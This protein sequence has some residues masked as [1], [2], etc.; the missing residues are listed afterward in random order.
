V[1]VIH[2]ANV[3]FGPIV[4]GTHYYLDSPPVAA[5]LEPQSKSALLHDFYRYTHMRIAFRSKLA[6]SH[7]YR[8]DIDGLR[9]IAVLAVVIFHAK[10]DLLPGGF[11]GVDIFFVISGYLITSIVLNDLQRSRFSI[12][13]F[14][15]RRVRRIFPALFAVLLFC[16]LAAAAMF[17]PSDLVSFG[18]A[19][20]AATGFASNIYFM[21]S[22]GQGGYFADSS[23]SQ[24]LLHTWTLS[25]EEQFYLF[26]PLILL[27]L[28]R[29]P[30]QR[31]VLVVLLLAVAS[32]ASSIWLTHYHPVQ[33]FYNLPSRAWELLAGALLALKCLPA[34]EKRAVRE[35]L[36]ACGL[37]LIVC[38][39]TLL[40]KD[41]T[42]P[43]INAI[44][45]CLG[46]SFMLYAGEQGTAASKS[47]L[48]FAPLVF[49][50][51]ISY[52]LY[53]WHWPLLVFARCFNAGDLSNVQTAGAVVASFLAAFFSYE[54]IERPFR[55]ADSR[56]SRRKI[57]AFGLV[58]SAATLLL[59]LAIYSSHGAPQRFNGT[60]RQIVMENAQRK[61]DFREVCSNWNTD[62]H[63]IEDIN[64]CTLG[65]NRPRKILFW[66]D[67][68]VQQLYPAIE[69]LFANG[70][71][72]VDGALVA[73]ENGCPP[74]EHMNYASKG[75]HCDSFAKLAMARAEMNDIDTVFIGFN[76]WWTYH[77]N[78][79]CPSLDGICVAHIS[80]D[81]SNNLFLQD[82]SSQ[83]AELEAHG[84]RVIV[85]LPFP[86]YDKSIPDL[87][88]RNAIFGRYGLGAIATDQ[89]L[90][91]F[92]NQ[93]AAT[94]KQ[95][96]A[97]IFDPRATLCGTQGCLTEEQGVSIYRDDHHIVAS[98]IAMFEDSLQRVLR[99][100][101]RPQ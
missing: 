18:K 16:L 90:P 88:I 8:A 20:I 26:F 48:S 23:N 50:G 45:P 46:A 42:F 93:L 74:D 80:L 27:L 82:M 30:K 71:L 85:A 73:V 1:N 14:Y 3:E 72:G 43:G 54:F 60:T 95:D 29:K 13:S 63:R 53:L 41:S 2:R 92:R 24:A 59:G 61:S 65:P 35:V 10:P 70:S 66:G 76:T 99:E 81:R 28:S 52:S 38:A 91:R 89:T 55:G 4:T 57:F 98:K 67:S 83:I 79:V 86:M 68:H 37:G 94:A 96:G 19:L 36:G 51:A 7:N 101:L 100:R 32:F 34:I 6:G 31:M 44:L 40:S 21:R 56:F 33:A 15:E 87:E 39:V 69:T 47:L 49:V 62:V 97:E 22:G 9:G 5:I 75:Y 64:F 84:K 25:V 58:A 12:V 77:E 78:A 11:V 17:A